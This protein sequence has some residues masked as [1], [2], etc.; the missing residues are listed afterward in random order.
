[1]QNST[2]GFRQGFA[3]QAKPCKGKIPLF[4]STRNAVITRRSG[5]IGRKSKRRTGDIFLNISPRN[6]AKNETTI[7]I[8]VGR[9][10]RWLCVPSEL[11]F[12]FGGAVVV[13]HFRICNPI[14][15]TPF[16]H[17]FGVEQ[18][19]ITWSY[20]VDICA[21]NTLK[22]GIIGIYR[23]ILRYRIGGIALDT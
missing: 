15:H 3:I 12:D 21:E 4:I 7:G 22:S 19:R 18:Y 13:C 14:F 16:L 9:S 8:S 23:V 6:A 11:S 10:C 5:K 2:N 17:H 1:M 20:I